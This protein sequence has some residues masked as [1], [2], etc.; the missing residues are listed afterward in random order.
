VWLALGVA[1]GQASGQTS[2]PIAG[3]VTDAF[4]PIQLVAFDTAAPRGDVAP[5]PPEV[6][7]PPRGADGGEDATAEP[8]TAAEKLAPG[9][10]Q[11][12]DDEKRERI[13]QIFGIR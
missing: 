6:I 11:L 1:A 3:V 9:E 5:E 4:E 7:P 12:T 8:Q 10:S 2:A 13:N